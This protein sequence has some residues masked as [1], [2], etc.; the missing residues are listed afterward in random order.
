MKSGLRAART[1]HYY[2]LPLLLLL[3]GMSIARSEDQEGGPLTIVITKS[4][5]DLDL[6]RTPINAVIL[7]Q[8]EL[9]ARQAN[10][11]QKAVSTLPSIFADRVGSRGGIGSVYLRGGDPNLT[12]VKIDGVQV[13]NPTNNRGG[14]YDLT[15]L[16]SSEISRIE[17]LSGPL[18]ALY[19]SDALA[20]AINI[21]TK[22]AHT[23]HS[24]NLDAG[25]GDKGG[26]H[27]RGYAAGPLDADK[28]RYYSF[29]ASYVDDGE[30]IEGDTFIGKTIAGKASFDLSQHSF[31]DI[32]ARYQSYDSTTFP[33]DSGGPVL[34]VI[35][36]I[37]RL[38]ATNSSLNLAYEFQSEVADYNLNLTRYETSE[39]SISPGVAPGVRDPFGIP[40]NVD[41]NDYIRSQLI[42]NSIIPQGERLDTSIGLDILNE[43]GDSVG[44]LRFPFGAMPTSF[45]LDRTTVAA[46]GGL[47]YATSS[48]VT[49]H[50]ALRYLDPESLSAELIPTIGLLYTPPESSLTLK[51]NWGQGFKLPSF[52]AL[53]NAIVGNPDLQPE[54]S[55]GG[56]IGLEYNIQRDTSLSIHLFRTIF[57][58]LID[59]DAG[60]PPILVNRSEVVARG[61]E[62]AFSTAI[63]STLTTKMYLSYTDTDIRDSTDRLRNR[64]RYR[65]GVNLGW[66]PRKDISLNT[67]IGFVGDRFDSSI[68]TGEQMLEE[69]TRVDVSA[70]WWIRKSLPLTVTIDNFLDKDYEDA[71]GFPAPQRR[72]RLSLGYKY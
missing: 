67:D 2:L 28:T 43:K 45:N 18:S 37:N 55:E 57:Q 50:G 44:A 32:S 11:A 40:A 71:I 23:N 48:G 62:I 51:A 63:S 19:G 25:L 6:T 47:R 33:E 24:V 10:S 14:S 36:D 15:A 8:E 41:D 17:V 64:P 39:K 7:D 49:F 20:G 12:A 21:Y 54:T 70:R 65:A 56:E 46:V 60:P 27:I 31:F 4:R 69:F 5:Q 35:R 26:E 3:V 61:V 1:L 22:R 72:L 29:G 13:N 34:A 59:F 66:T 9:E 38:E 30:P 53:A 68:P 58:N 16:D 42:F 52:F